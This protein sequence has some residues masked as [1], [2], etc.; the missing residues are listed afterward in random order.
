MLKTKNT[1][2]KKNND[3][4]VVLKKCI[5]EHSCSVS[6]KML[7]PYRGCRQ[8]AVELNDT[9]H[10]YIWE[11]CDKDI[12]K[13]FKSTLTASGVDVAEGASIE[14]GPAQILG[15]LD[16]IESTIKSI[17]AKNILDQLTWMD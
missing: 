6:T 14:F 11:T 3:S 13:V 1:H 9:S 10:L 4:F 16:A 8:L 7:K 5:E 2:A 12:Y 17:N 15:L